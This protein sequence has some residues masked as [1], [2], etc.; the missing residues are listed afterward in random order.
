MCL[1]QTWLE[2]HQMI[3]MSAWNAPVR[4][5]LRHQ[6]RTRSFLPKGVLQVVVWKY[7]FLLWLMLFDTERVSRQSYYSTSSPS[8]LVDPSSSSS[9]QFII[10]GNKGT[11]DLP[12]VF[13]FW[14]LFSLRRQWRRWQLLRRVDRRSADKCIVFVICFFMSGCC[15]AC[16]N[17]RRLVPYGRFGIRLNVIVFSL[18]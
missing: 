5:P 18:R 8:Y 1:Y 4:F 14:A 11:V 9:C 12:C 15:P 10:L 16:I 13:I 7:L 2:Y 3:S 17:N 6:L